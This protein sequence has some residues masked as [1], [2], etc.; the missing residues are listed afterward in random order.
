M[1]P[2]HQKL[3]SFIVPAFL[4]ILLTLAFTS[5]KKEQENQPGPQ[6][7]T[8]LI[9]GKEYSTLAI[10]NQVWTTSNYAGPGG[11]PYKTGSEKPEYGRYYTLEETNAIPVP[12]GWRLPTRQD[13]TTLA[14]SQGIVFTSNRAMGQEVI[15]KL[16]S[17]TNWRTM[18][19]TNASGF[20][21]YPAGYRYQDSEP[22]DGDISE[23]WTAGGATFSIQEGA[24]GKA[25]NIVFYGD[26]GAG[27]RFTVRFVKDK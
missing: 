4:S 19:G 17:V 6:P 10:G 11:L 18:P 25:H 1:I 20:N 27:Y 15:K 12:V 5:C 13:Y 9:N 3:N 26:G 16:T 8:V 14:E 24:T 22:M 21:A 7:N 2:I 23:F